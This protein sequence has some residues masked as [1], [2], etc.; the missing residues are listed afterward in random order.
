VDTDSGDFSKCA[1]L[2][3]KDKLIAVSGLAIIIGADMKCSY[4]AG[5][6][7]KDLKHQMLWKVKQ[8]M[9]AVKKDGIRGMS[10]SWGLRGWRYWDTW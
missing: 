7:R 1:L 6:W 5:M 9:P 2:Y 4:L 10:G 8:A 3:S